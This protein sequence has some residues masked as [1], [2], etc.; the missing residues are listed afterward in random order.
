MP[1]WMGNP[2]L[3]TRKRPCRRSFPSLPYSLPCSL[4]C[5]IRMVSLF[6]ATA[7]LWPHIH[8]LLADTRPPAAIPAH[9]AAAADSITLTLMPGGAGTATTIHGISAIPFTCCTNSRLKVEL[10]LLM[11]FTDARRHDSKNFLYAMDDLGRNGFGL[12]PKN[13]C[14]DSAHDNIPPICSTDRLLT[15]CW[16]TGA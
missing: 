1:S 2:L 7:Q 4:A 15:S 3:K 6:P 5:L 10:P 9:S 8:P 14:L 16:N 11:K 13:V 12:S